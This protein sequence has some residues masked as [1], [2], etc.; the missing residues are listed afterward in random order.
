VSAEIHEFKRPDVVTPHVTGPA[1]CCDCKHEWVVM[2][3]QKAFEDA[4][5]WLECPA[6]ALERGRFKYPHQLPP[7]SPAWQCACSN[8]LFNLTPDGVHCPNCGRTQVF[9]R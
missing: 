5:G 4:D 2:V 6:C 7:G 1:V 3:E 8:K 9:P